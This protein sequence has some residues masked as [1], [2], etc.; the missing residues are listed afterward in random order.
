MIDTTRAIVRTKS[1]RDDALAAERARMAEDVRA[2]AVEML[3]EGD[4]IA[5]VS[6]EIGERCLAIFQRLPAKVL[7]VEFD[8][9]ES[10]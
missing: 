7:A 1:L 3:I 5:N 10:A 2:V 6:E 8:E 9:I 4:A